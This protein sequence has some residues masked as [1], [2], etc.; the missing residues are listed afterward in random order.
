MLGNFGYEWRVAS[1]KTRTPYKAFLSAEIDAKIEVH[2][3]LRGFNVTLEGVSLCDDETIP[4]PACLFIK[5]Y[6]GIK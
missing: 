2:V 6:Q 4:N 1:L 5:G 3:G